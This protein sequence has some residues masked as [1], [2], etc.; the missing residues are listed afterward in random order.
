MVSSMFGQLR[1]PIFTYPDGVIVLNWI[2]ATT[3]I[4]PIS[5][6]FTYVHNL[7]KKWCTNNITHK[8]HHYIKLS[9]EVLSIGSPSLRKTPSLLQPFKIL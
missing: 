1:R 2:D 8:G 6:A 5:E 7:V 4:G 9:F 3:W